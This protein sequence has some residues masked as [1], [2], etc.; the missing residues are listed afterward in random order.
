MVPENVVNLCQAAET[1]SSSLA[2]NPKEA[3]GD[4]IKRLYGHLPARQHHIPENDQPALTEQEL[5]TI[6]KCGRWG[7]SQPSKLF[8]QAFASS[9]R[10]LDADPMAGMVSPPLMGSHGT[11]PLTA[12]APLADVVRHCSNLIVRAQR[13]VFFITCSWCPSVAQ[14]L[15]KNA[16]IELSRRAGERGQRVVVKIMYDKA[17]A[18]NAVEARQE[19][20]PKRGMSLSI[21]QP[22]GYTS[23]SIQLPSPDQVPN[24][25][26]EVMSFH[27]LVLGTLHAK[28]CV[29]DRQI[30]VIMSNNIEDNCNMEMMTHVEGPI[31]SSVYDTALITWN[32]SFNPPLPLL[33]DRAAENNKSTFDNEPL[34]LD[35]GRG[36]DQGTIAADG[37]AQAGLPE[38]T[39]EDPHY[40]DTLEREIDR[41]QSCYST[42]PHES[43]LQAVN[44]QLNLAVQNPIQPSGPE[45]P[46]GAEMTPY[47][48]T[49][50][51]YPVPIALVS[52]PPYG[53]MDAKNVNVPQNEAWLSLIRNAQEHIFIQTPDLNAAP[54]ISALVAALKRGVEVTYYVC[55]GYNDAGEMMPGQGGTN[56]QAT[57]SLIKTL[58][59]DGPER[60]LLHVYQYVAKDQDHPI[61]QKVRARACHVKLLIVD[62]TVGVQG[63]GNQDTQSWFHSQEVNIMVDSPAICAQWREGIER[64]QN[65]KLFGRV[66]DDGVWRDKEGKPG[67][68]YTGDY[69]GLIGLI[70]AAIGMLKFKGMGGF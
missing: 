58:P 20:K 70:K 45:I 47:I 25:D 39:P 53:P 31:A 7:T 2:K 48:S 42:K 50:T 65:T 52:R 37:H 13:E 22:A 21:L 10:C 54:L 63:S 11:I 14:Q 59:P 44:R 18:A 34:Y 5:E 29:V 67:E 19:V 12:I 35:R 51:E 36:R 49:S 1:V 46:D 32:K 62:N 57:H 16:L 26:M 3:P 69:G 9:L 56:E 40:D 60:K 6:L 24:L 64:N 15:I 27:K 41:M 23:T 38:H 30:A 61:H 28:F 17:A 68:G 43:R 55:F 4:A 33:D 66:G 8:L